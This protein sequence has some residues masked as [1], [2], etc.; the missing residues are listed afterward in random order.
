MDR[1]LSRR[2]MLRAGAVA[3]VAAAALV[4]VPGASA[5]AQTPAPPTATPQAKPNK[6]AQKQRV[7][8]RLIIVEVAAGSPAEKAGLKIGES[9][10][11]IDGKSVAEQQDLAGIVAAKKPGDTLTLDVVAAD[12]AKRS[13]SVTLGDNP[14]K[15]GTA[16]LGIRFGGHGMR[17]RGGWG[18][19]IDTGPVT[20]AEVQ[21]GSPAG[22]AGVQ[23]GDVITEA[24]GTTVTSLMSLKRVLAGAKPGDTLTLKVTRGS[25]S[26][27]LTVTLGENPTQ[28]GVAYLGLAVSLPRMQVDPGPSASGTQG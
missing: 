9:I 15:A 18:R 24:N 6:R 17:G 12:G 14:S 27:T 22:K 25:A 26:Q 10:T 4:A 13:V 23:V 21:A 19:G 5:F 8:D 11:T 1:L 20:V 16:Y 2:A 7:I 3:T 28:K